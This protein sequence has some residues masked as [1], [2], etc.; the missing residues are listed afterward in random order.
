[1]RHEKKLQMAVL[2]AQCP[3]ADGT[4]EGEASVTIENKAT[5]ANTTTIAIP[6]QVLTMKVRLKGVVSDEAELTAYDLTGEVVETTTGYDRA[7]K[8]DLIDDGAPTDGTRRFSVEAAGNKIDGSNEN[9]DIRQGATDHLS[10]AE[11]NRLIDFVNQALPM[12]LVNADNAFRSSRE[13]WRKGFCVDVKLNAP[14]QKLVSGEQIAVSAETVHKLDDAKIDARLEAEGFAEIAPAAQQAKPSA[15]FTVTASTKDEFGAEITVKSVSRRGIGTA[16]LSFGKEKPPSKKPPVRKPPATKKCTGAWTGKIKVEK[17]KREEKKSP[18]SGRL[19][20]QIEVS[21]ETFSIGYNLLGIADTSKGL[22]NGTFAEAQMDYRLLKYQESTYAPGK[23]SCAKKIITSTETRK[24]ESLTT[25]SSRGR[26]TVYVTSTGEKGFLTFGS[27]ELQAERV[28]TTRYETACPDYDR[29]NSSVDN[30]PGWID[31]SV[32]S[33]EIEF[34]LGA[35][36]LTQLNGSK[37]I[38]NEDGGE[39]LVTWTL[40]RECQ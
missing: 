21:D 16:T 38:Q 22:L 12:N 14:K 1:V 35:E 37:T 30:G 24:I 23:M 15:R 39:T 11:N 4:V 29:V 2:L 26:L 34:E 28:T 9:P 7:K 18:E 10:N 27:P 40:T 13:N 17:R 20:R 33:F 36:S 25:G 5:I 3:S 8:L 31:I 6:A 19:V 32:P